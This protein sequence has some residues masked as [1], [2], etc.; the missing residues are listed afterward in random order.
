M[1]HRKNLISFLLTFLILLF[2]IIGYSLLLQ[3]KS[4]A[5]L[6]PSKSVPLRTIKVKK[7]VA[8][9]V[10]S[11]IPVD[12]RVS[13][14]EQVHLSANVAGQIMPIS[15]QLRKGKFFEKGAL[16]FE[17]DRQK[18]IYNLNAQRGT[19]L[20]AIIQLM[21]DLKG[22]YPEAHLKWKQYLD[23]FQVEKLVKDLPE[24]TN[25]KEKYFIATQNIF[26]RF[27]KI[28]SAEVQLA[29][30]LI[31]AP[32]SGV[33]TTINTFPGSTVMPGTPLATII[34]T[35]QFELEA[36]ISEVDL[37]FIKTGSKVSLS[38]TSAN[39][40]WIGKVLRI[41]AEIDP[42]TQSIPIYIQVS[43]TDLK[44]G[45]Y[46][47]GQIEGVDIAAVF[48]I[49]K[50]Y[51]FNQNYIHLVKDSIITSSKIN[52]RYQ[53]EQFIYADAFPTNPWIVYESPRGIYKEQKIIP[54]PIKE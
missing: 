33:I 52:I 48:S 21:P 6:I 15:N 43:G 44:N 34:N 50:Q 35:Q 29:E 5:K 14:L 27:Y 11:Y 4:G 9:T 16:L 28:K 49:P 3:Q 51:V 41:G 45:L 46:L 20:N 10:T 18:A 54:M 36:T 7:A 13:T 42:V 12:G 8:Q 47:N 17:I 19:L 22:D 39:K 53:D 24:I 30:Y 2:G 32:F 26:E 31:Y 37:S 40:K 1:L 23:D 38:A 25:E